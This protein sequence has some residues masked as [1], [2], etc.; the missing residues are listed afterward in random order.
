M[1][2]LL[3]QRAIQERFSGGSCT[4]DDMRID[5]RPAQICYGKNIG[6]EIAEA[7]CQCLRFG[8]IPAPDENR[9]DVPDPAVCTNNVWGK[10]TR[11]NHEEHARITASERACRK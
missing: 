6:P 2:P 9:T 7:S 4:A 8:P 1:A 5:D 10:R 11:S 3:H